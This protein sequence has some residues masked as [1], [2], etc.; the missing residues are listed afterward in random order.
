MAEQGAV[1][2][3]AEQRLKGK[4]NDVK[5]QLAMLEKSEKDLALVECT[6]TEEIQESLCDIQRKFVILR[7]SFNEKEAYC[8]LKIREAAEKRMKAIKTWREK[9][10]EVCARA[11]DVSRVDL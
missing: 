7:E 6:M 2:T 4:E 8:C 11:R 3:A 5:S 9:S 1:L 10:S